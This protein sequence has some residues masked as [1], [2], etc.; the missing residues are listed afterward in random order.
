MK[1]IL[2][3][4]IPILFSI[5]FAACSKDNKGTA[6]T[7]DQVGTGGSLAR[8][9]ISNGHLYVV[10]MQELKAFSL[11]NPVDPVLTKTLQV[12]INVETIFVFEDK[13]FIGSQQAMYIYSIAN[14]SSPQLLGQASHVRACDPVIANQ[15]Y[16]YV[17][18]RSGTNCGGTTNALYVYDVSNI[19]NP[20]QR[21]V[22]PLE[23]PYGLGM[24]EDRLYICD[25]GNGLQ[26]YN[27]TNPEYPA[28]I[29]EVSGEIFYD[30]IIDDADDLLI[31]MVEG[32][33][34][35]YKVAGDNITKLSKIVN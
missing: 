11:A 35:I 15:D 26:V 1:K 33:T 25:G 19:L 5:A 12:G 8:F 14:P 13:L 31:C 24:R 29:K 3:L 22:V 30:I 10:E 9:T 16:A 34:A 6:S 27:I 23:T 18:V 4:F 2:F 17:T 32:G 7:A 20:I 28:F 21:N